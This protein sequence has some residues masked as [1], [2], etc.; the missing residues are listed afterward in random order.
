MM[1]VHDDLAHL[2]ALTLP[3]LRTRWVKLVG[4]PAP[5]VGTNMLRLALAW[6][7][8]ARAHGG[9]ARATT[10]VLDQLGRAK[11]QIQTL[12]LFSRCP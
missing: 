12:R 5:K 7:I 10:Q 8:Q 2:D 11:T 9:L 4:T 6:E 1:P 3:E